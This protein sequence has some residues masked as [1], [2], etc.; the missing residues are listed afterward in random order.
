MLII[1]SYSYASFISS[2][3]LIL[4]ICRSLL[5]IPDRDT[6]LTDLSR[7]KS[8]LDLLAS[9]TNSSSTAAYFVRKLT[10]MYDQS[11]ELASN[12]GALSHRWRDPRMSVHTVLNNHRL[13]DPSQV[14]VLLGEVV[15]ALVIPDHL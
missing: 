15:C 5:R 3:I 14:V 12:F 7:V 11:K 9:A 13:F 4:S 10:P 1:F 6:I 2:D 8:G